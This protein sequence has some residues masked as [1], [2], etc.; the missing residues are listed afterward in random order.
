MLVLYNT[1]DGNSLYETQVPI[2]YLKSVTSVLLYAAANP[3]INLGLTYSEGVFSLNR[4]NLGSTLW[5][6]RVIAC[7]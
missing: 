1:D 5:A 2:S 3:N 7:N 6:G 4:V